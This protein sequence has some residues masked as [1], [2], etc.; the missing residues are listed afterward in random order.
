MG[1]V[2]RFNIKTLSYKYRDLHHNSILV[3][4]N[5]DVEYPLPTPLTLTRVSQVT[6]AIHRKRVLVHLMAFFY[7]DKCN[8]DELLENSSKPELNP[9]VENTIYKYKHL[10]ELTSAVYLTKARLCLIC[11]Q[12]IGLSNSIVVWW[13]N[14]DCYNFLRWVVVRQTDM[15]TKK[16]AYI[17]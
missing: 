12:S 6:I 11:N 8:C 4:R 16:C 7:D 17:V 5:F 3:R 9:I 1:R 2:Y 15:F 13:Q 14:S 10:A